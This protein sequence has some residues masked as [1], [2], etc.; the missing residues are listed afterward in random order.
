MPEDDDA[1]LDQLLARGRLSGRQYDEIER[2]VLARV[3]PRRTRWLRAAAVPAAALSCAAIVGLMLVGRTASERSH[4]GLLP[5]ASDGFRARGSSALEGGA[6]SP[7]AVLDVGCAGRPAHVCHIGDTLLFSVTGNPSA[8]YLH[9]F[10]ERVAS[11]A[12]RIWYFSAGAANAPL[13][14]ARVATNV[15]TQGVRLGPPH[16]VGTYRVTA[17]VAPEAFDEA[18]ALEQSERSRVTPIVLAIVE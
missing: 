6:P 14:P 10:A 16:T 15:L 12:P 13:V 3:V 17:W 2:H 18:R 8:G 11:P 1:E 5:A 7:A 9:A 4:G